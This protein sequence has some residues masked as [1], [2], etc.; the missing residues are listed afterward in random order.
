MDA[1]EYAIRVFNKHVERSGLSNKL[2][3]NTILE[4]GPGDSVATAVVAAAH[5]AQ[6]ILIDSGRFVRTDVA[7]YLELERVLRE[8]GK[9]PPHLVGCKDIGEIL[10]HCKARYMTNGLASFGRIE[11]ASVDMI[12]SQAVLEHVR[13]REFLEMIRECR[14][15]LKP[16]GVCSHQVD[17]SDHLSGALNNR[18]F[19]EKV[20]ESEIFVRSGFYTNRISFNEMPSLFR[21]A[22]FEIEVSNVR[23]W[24]ELPTPRNR[25]SR[26]F[27]N[28]SDEDLCV[29]GF[30]VF[31][32]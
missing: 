13:K 19:S 29:S 31:L 15:V 20:W 26:E 7:S 22:G 4:I 23:R 32:W 27:K 9:F 16:G 5:G 11:S 14:R 21:Q 3:G 10:T 6:A 18:R 24:P 8:N 25:L 30:E 1:S 12:F 17:L 28:L 2:N